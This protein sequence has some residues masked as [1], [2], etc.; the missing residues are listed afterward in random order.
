M[1]VRFLEWT[2][3]G[4]V[5]LTIHCLLVP[6]SWEFDY[7][8]PL[9][10]YPVISFVALEMLAAGVYL[11][12]LWLIPRSRAERRLLALVLGVGL[13]IRAVTMFSTPILED[14]FYRYLWD[15]AVVAGGNDP[16]RFSPAE[17]LAADGDSAAELSALSMLADASTPV[18][19][20]SRRRR[21]RSRCHRPP[22][23]VC[24]SCAQGETGRNH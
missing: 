15:G 23:L 22:G 3:V 2:A 20:R 21:R 14:D 17:V 16:Y 1:R 5:L 11:T 6:L 10:S 13:V 19:Q 9:L 18:A 4:M 24:A 12:L 8:A 7:D